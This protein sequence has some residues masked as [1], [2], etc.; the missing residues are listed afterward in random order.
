MPKIIEQTNKQQNTSRK[1]TQDVV[2]YILYY[3][4]SSVFKFS[5]KLQFNT[6]S[7]NK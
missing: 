3:N 2:S 6:N 4:T 7:N 5:D 1:L